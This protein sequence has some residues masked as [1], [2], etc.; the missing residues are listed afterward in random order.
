MN[1]KQ[2]SKWTWEINVNTRN[3]C[4]GEVLSSCNPFTVNTFIAR[5]ASF[6]SFYFKPFHL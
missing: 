4:I 3:V 1:S 6:A 5:L 2:I